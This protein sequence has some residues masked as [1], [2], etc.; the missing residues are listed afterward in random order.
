MLYLAVQ[1]TA[2]IFRQASRLFLEILLSGIDLFSV[3]LCVILET[4]NTE[5]LPL[6]ELCSLRRDFG[7][8]EL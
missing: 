2:L 7:R 1:L 4:R 5:V 6:A 8:A 3:L